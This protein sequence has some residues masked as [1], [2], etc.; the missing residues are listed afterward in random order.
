MTSHL[1]RSVP[2]RTVRA[3]LGLAI[4]ATALLGC[5]DDGADAD[6]DD[7]AAEPSASLEGVETE[8]VGD[9]VHVDPGVD[10]EYP[11]PAPSGGDHIFGATWATC[12]VYVGEVPD[13]LV[14]HS[15]E[16]GAVWI[17]LGPDSTEDDRSAAAELADGRR[18][19]VSDVPDLPNPVELVAWGFRLPLASVADPRAAAFVDEFID[20]P[21]APEA[22]AACEGALGTPPN[23]PELPTS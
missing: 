8:R 10:L 18:V 7:A 5:S 9:Y 13:P 14:V 22:G 4:A 17:A 12:G 21:T 2:R 19:V 20:A 6:A 23:P 11:A 15:L 16:H 1:S 3:G